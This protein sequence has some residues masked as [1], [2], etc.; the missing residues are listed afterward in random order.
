MRDQKPKIDLLSDTSSSTGKPDQIQYIR[1]L[2]DK[3][4]FQIVMLL[5]IY[6]EM[7]VTQ[8][9]NLLNQSKATVSRHLAE[10]E[11][12][13]VEYSEAF[14]HREIEGRI[15]PKYY[16]IKEEFYKNIKPVEALHFPED[17]SGRR[18]FYGYLI[19]LLR[20]GVEISKDS[21]NMLHSLL[22]F[23]ESQMDDPDLLSKSFESYLFSGDFMLEMI[24]LTEDQYKQFKLYVTE[25]NEKVAQLP[26]EISNDESRPY[27]FIG[28][29]FNA[30]KLLELQAG[31]K[32]QKRPG[33]QKNT[34]NG[35]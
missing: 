19:E 10:M 3:L 34:G 24:W 6:H 8:I 31:M 27:L 16:R 23:L 33:K 14:K 17:T 29:L 32:E 12:Q 7:N 25:F 11:G 28:S 20:N 22:D 18:Q 4:K 35:R 2:K 26:S 5:L 30:A 21:I 15:T 9:S 13:V 1:I